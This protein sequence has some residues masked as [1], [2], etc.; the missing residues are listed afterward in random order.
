MDG[1]FT[2]SF[3]SFSMFAQNQERKGFT[4]G[5]YWDVGEEEVGVPEKDGQ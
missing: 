1:S 3:L 5:H 2:I 4:H